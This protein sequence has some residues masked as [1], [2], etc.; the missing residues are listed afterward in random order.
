M[1]RAWVGSVQVAKPQAS[2]VG[3]AGTWQWHGGDITV[4]MIYGMVVGQSNGTV[5]GVGGHEGGHHRGMVGMMMVCWQWRWHGGDGDGTVRMG[6]ARWG[7]GVG[8][9]C[10]TG[11]HEASLVPM[12]GG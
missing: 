11:G 4:G 9:G 6:M 8:H 10:G 1:I 12:P 5:A 2:S 7:Q 3:A